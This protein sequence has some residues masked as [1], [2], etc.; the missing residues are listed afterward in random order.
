[1]EKLEF[2]TDEDV[3]YKDAKLIGDKIHV[4]TNLISKGETIEMLYKFYKVKTAWKI[5]DLEIIGVSVIQTYRSQLD[6]LMKAGGAD[7]L[8]KQL[9]TVGGLKI[10]EDPENVAPKA[11]PKKP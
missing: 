6:G 1:M 10:T 5:Y 2:Y 7:G 8:F 3:V 11:P 9:R 4:M